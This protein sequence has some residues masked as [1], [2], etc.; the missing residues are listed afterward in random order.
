MKLTRGQSVIL[1]TV[2]V[3]LMAAV[4]F[5]VLRL[6]RRIADERERQAA[7]TRVEVE[8]SLLRAPATDGLTP[9]LNASDVRAVA[10]FAGVTYL[11]TSGGLIALDD[12]GNV[13]RRFTTLDGLPD[14]DL[15]ALSVFR[16]RLFVGTANAGL[17]SFDGQSFRGYRFTRPKASHFSVLGSTEREL[18]IGTLDGGLFEYNG[19]R[20]AR[21]F[22]STAGADFSRV[23]ALLPVESRM[24]IGTQDGGLYLWRE[25]HIE[26]ITTNEGLPSPHVTGLS[27][28]PSSFAIGGAVAVATDFG[29]VAIND[30]NEIKPIFKR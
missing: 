13:K 11:A 2:G 1:I 7:A 22:N 27:V 19:D 20:F 4:V 26:Q 9:Y 15:T 3:S 28:L 17:I 10:S 24:Y 6:N 21:R 23:T 25:A 29:V 8:E 5:Y 16:E 30:A 14:N 18:L 12:V